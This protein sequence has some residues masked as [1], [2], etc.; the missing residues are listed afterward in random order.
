MSST[1]RGSERSPNDFYETQ[2]WMT[3][4]ALLNIGAVHWHA[5]HVLECAAGTGAITREVRAYWPGAAIREI[6]IVRTGE[7]FL[8]VP[9]HPIYDLVI[10][11]PP[12]SLAMEFIQQSHLWV[13]HTPTATVAMLLPLNFLG[14]EKRAGWLRAHPPGLYVSPQRPSFTG[15]KTDS[16]NYAWMMWQPHNPNFVPKVEILGM[17]TKAEVKA[18]NLRIREAIMAVTKESDA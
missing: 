5:P 15:G 2:G 10:T 8:A 7:D 1:N 4:L 13:R 11:N 9:P 6:D 14:S 3:R 18:D 16:I 17:P 12:F